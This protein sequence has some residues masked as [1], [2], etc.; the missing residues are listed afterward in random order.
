MKHTNAY[1]LYIYPPTSRRNCH[2]QHQQQYTPYA[3]SKQSNTRQQQANMHLL[4]VSCNTTPTTQPTPAGHRIP[5]ASPLCGPE[6]KEGP[7]LLGPLYTTHLVYTTQRRMGQRVQQHQ[8]HQV[9]PCGVGWERITP[10]H[11]CRPQRP[12]VGGW[13]GGAPG[14]GGEGTHHGV[15]H[16]GG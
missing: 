3:A 13:G 4:H 10:H 2:K 8:H 14:V 6:H 11:P 7:P 5:M 15:N 9:G 1:T 12:W 16:R